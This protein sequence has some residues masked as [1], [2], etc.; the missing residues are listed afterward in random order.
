M[1]LLIVGICTLL[2]G[3]FTGSAFS[4]VTGAVVMVASYFLRK[5]RIRSES[6]AMAKDADGND[7]ILH[8]TTVETFG[9]D[10][11]RWSKVAKATLI[12]VSIINVTVTYLSRV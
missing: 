3:L 5:P 11:P 6:Y 12:I 1:T 10:E 8:S 4:V 2:T 7:K 9:G